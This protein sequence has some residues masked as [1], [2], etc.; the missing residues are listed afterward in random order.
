MSRIVLQRVV[1]VV[2]SSNEVFCVNAINDARAKETH[3][4][5]YLEIVLDHIKNELPVRPRHILQDG[6]DVYEHVRDLTLD[7]FVD[8]FVRRDPP[9]AC[10]YKVNST[11]LWQEYYIRLWV[12]GGG[13]ETT[14]QKEA[15]GVRLACRDA[16]DSCS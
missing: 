13:G 5:T 9:L 7:V 3:N 6:Y 1:S 4:P 16:Q 15:I 8:V 2:S 11:E 14:Q 10:L 12:R